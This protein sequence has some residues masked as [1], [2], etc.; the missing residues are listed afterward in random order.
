MWLLNYTLPARG[1]GGGGGGWGGGGPLCPGG[2]YTL[3]NICVSF[4]CLLNNRH[5]DHAIE[6]V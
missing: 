4:C 6:N 3:F 2:S 5:Y 1:G